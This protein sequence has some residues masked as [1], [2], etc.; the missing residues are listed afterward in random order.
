LTA[1]TAL[2]RT[3][4]L[5]LCYVCFILTGTLASPSV[6]S[7]LYVSSDTNSSV[8]CIAGRLTHCPYLGPISYLAT[9]LLCLFCHFLSKK[10]LRIIKFF[11]MPVVI[12]CGAIFVVLYMYQFDG[13][14][15]WIQ[16][17]WPIDQSYF[18]PQ[19][20]GLIEYGSWLQLALLGNACSYVLAVLQGWALIDMYQSV[21]RMS[22]VPQQTPGRC[23]CDSDQ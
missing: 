17:H 21:C 19:D 5:I 15:N 9:V 1:L 2:F 18:S 23:Y 16:N 10:S 11:W 4:G 13:I 22:S 14:A 6:I 7:G 20:L 12:V 3:Y 8:D